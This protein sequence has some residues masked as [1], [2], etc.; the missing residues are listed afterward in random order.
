LLPAIRRWLDKA[1]AAVRSVIGRVRASDAARSV[2]G[3]V[4]GVNARLSKT[5]GRNVPAMR[6]L[7]RR[8]A[9]SRAVL[10]RLL[11]QASTAALASEDGED[12]HNQRR[13]AR[14]MFRAGLIIVILSILSGLLTYFVLT[15]LTPITPTHEV[16]ITVWLINGVLITA[17]ITIVALQLFGLWRA[18]QREAAGAQLHV[19]IV[20]LFG[21]VALFPAILLAVFASISLDRGLDQWFSERTN[22]I[23]SDSIE[24]ANAYLT[25]HGKTVRADA[26]GMARDLENAARLLQDNPDA[27]RRYASLLAL[28]RRLPYAYLVNS[29]GEAT[30]ELVKKEGE[31]F[32]APPPLALANAADGR[33]VDATLTLSGGVGA[34]KRLSNFDDLYLYVRRPVDPTVIGHLRR[35]KANFDQYGALQERRFGVQVAFAMMYVV[36]ALTLLLASIW[37]GLWFAS[38][39]VAPIRR[40]I[41]AAQE[42]SKGNLDV[43]VRVESVRSDTG[44]LASTF[45]RMTQDLR[46]QRDALVGANT[47][48]DERRRFSEVVLSGVTA[49]VIGVGSNGVITLANSSAT[50]LLGREPNEL[51]GKPIDEAVPEFA[52][53][54]AKVWGHARR[55][56]Q[57]QITYRRASTDLTFSVRVTQEVGGRK[58]YGFVVTFDDITELVVAQR[59]SAWADVARRIAHEIKN[60]LTPIQ[61][62]AERVRRKYGALI[63]TDRDIFDRCTDTIIRHVGDIGRMVDEFSA[64]ARMPKPVFETHDVAAIVKEAVILFQMSNS[65]VAYDL[66]LP[67]KPL[68]I[69]CDRGLLTQATTNLVKNAGEAIVTA[70]QSGLKGDDY[71]GRIVARVTQQGTR[72]IVEVIDN[73][74]GLPAENRNRLTEPYVTTRQKGTG[75]G[76]A[77]VHRIAE[78]HD[79]ALELD[80]A[81]DDQ[82]HVTGAIVRMAIPIHRAAEITEIPDLHG[83]AFNGEKPNYRPEG[84]KRGV[85]YGV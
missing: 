54:V 23:I 62:S 46:S 55:A 79:G 49:G 73:G 77:I 31:S 67:E 69:E 36:I 5:F 24:V 63:T 19:R 20:S 44:Q 25:E 3:A 57:S 28:E 14:R 40:L 17:M 58:D 41:G 12:D 26:L 27:F 56:A 71:Q 1:I 7:R 35:T 53:I 16:V 61:L 38:R 50:Q 2:T 52:A 82:G 68:M 18:R 29:R 48:L 33:I 30:I 80:D 10:R 8:I 72:C 43:A 13:K 75:L 76:L 42:I 60:P 64:F 47:A 34:V 85:S 51:I 37:I 11:R 4:A 59:T 66:G 45:N 78:Q 22:T 74:C 84:E 21:V 6:S 83:E 39:L 32:E 9:R 65:E 81:V 70:R 15:G